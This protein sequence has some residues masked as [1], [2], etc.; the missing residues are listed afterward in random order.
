MVKNDKGQVAIRHWNS[1]PSPRT[2]PQW[3]VS[4]GWVDEEILPL[5]LSEKARICC[6]VLKQKYTIA[7]ELDVR[8]WKTGSQH[9]EENI[10]G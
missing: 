7:T 10:N 9:P 5:V 2:Q 6:G 1:N 3:G 8:I 4:L